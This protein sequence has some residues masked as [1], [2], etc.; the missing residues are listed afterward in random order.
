MGETKTRDHLSVF[1]FEVPNIA[2]KAIE[3]PVNEDLIDKNKFANNSEYVP[4]SV[5]RRLLNKITNYRWSFTPI[6]W[7]YEGEGDNKHAYFIGELVVPGFG[8][9][10]GVG[11][12]PMNKKG[13]TGNVYAL[14]SAK[15]YA[16][17]NACKEMGLAPNIGDDEYDTDLFED[18]E[19][20]KKIKK[21]YSKPRPEGDAIPEKKEKPSQGKSEKAPV[22]D[23]SK[24][25]KPSLN[26]RIQEV[27]DAYELDND[28]DFVAFLQIWD[29]DILDPEDLSDD[30]WE[31]FL[32]YLEKNKK[33]FEDF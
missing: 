11:T 33:K 28:D 16:F 13:S 20:E 15:T 14:A 27:R 24:K 18:E 32:N 9:H 17:K 10:T 23:K 30:M 22:P 26:D 5:Y 19:I 1:D 12:A 31:E 3:E 25:K 29:E 6:D 8:I 7:G 4:D 2:R 21:S